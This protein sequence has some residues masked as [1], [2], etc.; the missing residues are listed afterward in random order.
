MRTVTVND[1]GSPK[2]SPSDTIMSATGEPELGG[3]KLL[4][5]YS[6]FSSQG[7]PKELQDII[8]AVSGSTNASSLFDSTRSRYPSPQHLPHLTGL[9]FDHLACHFPFL[10]RNEVMTA[11]ENET[12]P[13]ILAN[14]LA[15]L[16]C[17]FSDRPELLRPKRHVAG[18]AYADMAKVRGYFFYHPSNN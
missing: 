8:G 7:S 5:R 1:V 17:R 2:S 6:F 13:A 16:A 11:V 4:G 18:E 14:C 3:N 9:F 15:S 10:D 12:L